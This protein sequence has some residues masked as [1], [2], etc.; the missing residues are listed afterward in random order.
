VLADIQ[1]GKFSPAT[2]AGEQVNQPVQGHPRQARP[3]PI[4]RSARSFANMMPWI[5]KGAL[6]RKIKN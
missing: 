5:K 1:S 6:C 4:E 2:G 3:A